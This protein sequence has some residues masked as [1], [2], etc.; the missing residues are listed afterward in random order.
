MEK[1]PQALF[2]L[3]E[4]DII[5]FSDLNGVTPTHLLVSVHNEL[6]DL[7]ADPKDLDNIVS[8]RVFG[9]IAVHI[10]DRVADVAMFGFHQLPMK[11]NQIKVSMQSIKESSNNPLDTISAGKVL[12]RGTDWSTLLSAGQASDMVRDVVRTAFISTL[13]PGQF[14]SWFHVETPLK[15]SNPEAFIIASLIGMGEKKI[16]TNNELLVRYFESLNRL[17]S[18]PKKKITKR[19]ISE[20]TAV[21]QEVLCLI[22]DDESAM[23]YIGNH[24]TDEGELILP[25]WYDNYPSLLSQNNYAN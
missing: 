3:M 20:H 15:S 17:D 24:T 21:E 12:K 1:T 11:A 19:I 14:S 9:P 2:P 13:E 18:L 8:Q 4:A 5:N 16:V 22:R 10:S 25:V 7:S 6:A 23:A